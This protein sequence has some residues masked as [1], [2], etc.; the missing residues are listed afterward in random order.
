MELKEIS[1]GISPCPNDTF[2]FYHLLHRKDLP[3]RFRLVIADVE[4]LNNMVLKGALDVSK[5]SY[6]LAAKVMDRYLVLESGSALGRGCGPL[7]LAREPIAKTSLQRAILAVPGMHTTATLLLRL[8]LP[9]VTRLEP[10]LFSRIPGAILDKEVDAGCVIHETRFTYKDMGLVCIEDL[11]LWWENKTQMPLP[12]GGIIAKRGL[13]RGLVEEIDQ[14]IRQSIE[15]ALKHPDEPLGFVRQHAQ[16]ISETVQREHI[17]LY[18]NEFS[19]CLGR[20]G[21]QAIRVLFD[22]VARQGFCRPVGDM[23]HDI[24]L[25][26]G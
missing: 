2:I 7:I 5:V 14:G 10:M 9:G 22:L 21:R 17:H 15:F 18:V 24:F 25:T 23:G 16:E 8:Y 12:L 20:E 6:G 4:K 3:F 1:L 11:G 13:P 19:I 26:G